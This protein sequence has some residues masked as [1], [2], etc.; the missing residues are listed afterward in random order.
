MR[1]LLIGVL[2][3]HAAIIHHAVIVHHTAVVHAAIHIVLLRHLLF[4]HVM[5]LHHFGVG[6][7]RAMHAG[8]IHRICLRCSASAGLRESRSTH[9]RCY[10]Y[11]YQF[12]H[13]SSLSA[14]D[15]SA[16]KPGEETNVPGV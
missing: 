3:G 14:I 16:R 12:S 7:N 15:V 13:V 8:F 9:Q 11:N 10:C 2:L 4:L 1:A 5:L 6:I